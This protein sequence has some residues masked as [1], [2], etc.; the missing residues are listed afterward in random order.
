VFW[1]FFPFSENNSLSKTFE[2][3]NFDFASAKNER[4]PLPCESTED[5]GVVGELLQNKL[6]C[7]SFYA[8]SFPSNIATTAANQTSVSPVKIV[9]KGELAGSKFVKSVIASNFYKDARRLGVPASV[10]DSVIKNLSSKIDFKRALKKGDSFEIVYGPRNVMLY[11]KIVT[12]RRQ[13][14]IYRFTN[15][16]NSAYYFENGEKA[17]T[18]NRSHYFGQPL[19]GKLQVSSAFGARV[20][21]MSGIFKVHTGVDLRTQYGS[22]V[23][24][25]F[26]G[27]VTRASS[28]HGYGHCVDIKH[29]SGYSSRYGHLSRYSVRCGSKVKKGQVIG[30]SGSSG[31]STGPHLHMELAKNNRVINPLSVKMTPREAEMVPNAA[32]FNRLKKQI[33]RILSASR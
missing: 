19:G 3:C 18:S 27:V 8:A 32:G 24:A 23:Y 28:Y 10:V 20:H 33:A 5:G 16:G 7:N 15:R 21:P 22:P 13:A 9:S 31:T 4:L 2:V 12:K 25:I 6:L 26:D 1:D 14:S 29:G 30:Y 11:S 17:D